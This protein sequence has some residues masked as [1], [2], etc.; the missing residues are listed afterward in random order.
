M[1]STLKATLLLIATFAGGALAGGAVIGLADRD[2]LPG[3]KYHYHHGDDDHIEFLSRKLELTPPQKD[4]VHSI[5]ER[6]KPAMD[7][8]W[9]QLGPR[10]ETIRD[11]ISNE[12]RRQ[13]TPKQQQ[14]YTE[15]IRRFEEE[16]R[17]PP[18]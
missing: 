15:M 5:L 9:R 1:R 2:K 13:L 8:L 17:G 14:A 4:S 6:H 16:R 7:S 18:E 12:I 11:S 3:R 10:F